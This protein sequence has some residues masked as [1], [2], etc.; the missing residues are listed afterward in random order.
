MRCS[1]FKY[2]KESF[3]ATTSG[4]CFPLNMRKSKMDVYLQWADCIV[5]F[6]SNSSN[7]LIPLNQSRVLESLSRSPS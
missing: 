4:F 6:M 2:L 7:S 1:L 5:K 3:A